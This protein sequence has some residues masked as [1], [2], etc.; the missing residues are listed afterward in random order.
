MRFLVFIKASPESEAGA[1]PDASIVTAMMKYNEDLAIA[2]VLLAA[3]GLH[4]SAKG[5]RVRF[6]GDRRMVIDG[7]FAETKE[8]IA[9]FWIWQCASMDE[10]L[11]W[12]KRAPV[13]QTELEIR[14]I[15]EMDEF[16]SQTTPEMRELEARIRARA[17]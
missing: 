2:G 3:E 17:S 14:P 15:F 11:E 16:D 7:P 12:L 9:G 10:A 8:V 6:D 1:F 13:D 5:K 4:P